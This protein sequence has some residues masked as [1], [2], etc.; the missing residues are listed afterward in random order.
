MARSIGDPLS[1]TSKVLVVRYCHRCDR[2]AV[3][4]PHEGTAYEVGLLG[5]SASAG[6]V[7]LAVDGKF[8]RWTEDG[9]Y[10][11]VAR[12]AYL[13]AIGGRV[14]KIE[15]LDGER[16]WVL[17]MPLGSASV[18]SWDDGRVRWEA[19]PRHALDAY[20][21]RTVN[22]QRKVRKVRSTDDDRI[23]HCHQGARCPDYGRRANA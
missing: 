20:E 7:Q 1:E 14:S 10:L 9:A 18:E 17:N 8:V 22:G 12:A 4:C 2:Q 23:C 21:P 16:W 6:V 15:V 11:R 19:I 13:H 5:G 3:S